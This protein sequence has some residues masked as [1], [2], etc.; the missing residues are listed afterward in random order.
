M[1]LPAAA[2]GRTP[3]QVFEDYLTPPRTPETPTEA[4]LV[5]RAARYRVRYDAEEVEVYA[6]GEGRPV[7]LVHGWG[8]RGTLMG[9]YVE[10]LL[11]AGLRVVTFD[12]PGHG[13]SAGTQCDGVRI[14]GAIEAIAEREGAF[15]SVIAHSVGATATTRA[16]TNGVRADRVA[17]IAPC[18]WVARTAEEYARAAGMDEAGVA[19]VLGILD[20]RYGGIVTS[21]DRMA[22]GLTT[23]LTIWHDRGDQE[24]GF[25]SAEAIHAAW[26]GSRLIEA[27]RMGHRRIVISHDIVRQVV[28]WLL[29]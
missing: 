1:T 17:F 5:E 4:R 12:G 20:Q 27:P 10:P 14:A 11:A 26:S 29:G 9:G 24:I 16:L 18:C 19:E 2:D 28:E 21:A 15:H 22:A 6:W 3:A 25:D 8:G 7:L 23:P 13:R